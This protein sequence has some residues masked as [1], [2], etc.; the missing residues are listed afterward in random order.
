ML[1]NMRL[2]MNRPPILD[3]CRLGTLIRIQIDVISVCHM[4]LV[5]QEWD[6][7]PLAIAASPGIS[8]GNIEL[9]QDC[10]NMGFY[11]GYGDI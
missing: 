10:V 6:R 11:C 2:S 4:Y 9:P 3:K 1:S 7:D 8:R 5:D